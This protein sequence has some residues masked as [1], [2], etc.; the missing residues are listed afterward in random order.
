MAPPKKMD[1][2]AQHIPSI[3]GRKGGR[4][5]L[6]AITAEP[7]GKFPRPL[8]YLPHRTKDHIKNAVTSFI[9]PPDPTSDCLARFSI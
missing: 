5:I 6:Q 7:S 3:A 9:F 2:N 4:A 1:F 8:D